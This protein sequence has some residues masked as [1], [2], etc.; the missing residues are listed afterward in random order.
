MLCSSTAVRSI[1]R[2]QQC[3]CCCA[4]N[5]RIPGWS[6]L[7]ALRCGFISC[8]LVNP[9][10]DPAAA[11][12]QQLQL[13]YAQYGSY[14]VGPMAVSPCVDLTQRMKFS[15][16]GG[17]SYNTS[18]YQLFLVTGRTGRPRTA[19]EVSFCHKKTDFKSVFFFVTKR[20]FVRWLRQAAQPAHESP[21]RL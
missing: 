15:M 18:G 21:N 2:Q 12:L 19:P 10:L 9:S 14:C 16:R 4:L 13:R 17:T 11:V 8:Q 20:R 7:P 5:H 1:V 3:H 6:S